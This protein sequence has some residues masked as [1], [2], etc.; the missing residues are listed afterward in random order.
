M[1]NNKPTT[2]FIISTSGQ[3]TGEFKFQ[4]FLGSLPE[5]IV[6][7]FPIA[8]NIIIPSTSAQLH[9]FIGEYES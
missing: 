3:N 4:V 2:P 9:C 8:S 1:A 7:K 6:I 5:E